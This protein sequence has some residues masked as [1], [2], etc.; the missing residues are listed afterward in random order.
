DDI[1]KHADVAMYEAKSSGR[2]NLALFDPETLARE[3]RRYR[4]VNELR[5]AFDNDELVLHFQ[6]QVDDRGA[7]CGAE[8]L[9]RWNHPTLGMVMPD[10]FVPLAEQFGL[11][12]ELGR[13]VFEKGLAELAAWQRD[14]AMAYVRLALNVSVQSF[15]SDRFVPL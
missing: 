11:N 2:N 5:T 13:C 12:D 10:Q 14:P 6:P 15:S 8:A 7:L 9:V 3:S 1:L 4:L